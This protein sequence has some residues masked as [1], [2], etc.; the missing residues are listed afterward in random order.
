MST[1]DERDLARAKTQILDHAFERLQEEAGLSRMDAQII[2]DDLEPVL[3]AGLQ[4]VQALRSLE[5]D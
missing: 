5:A 4:A 2:I 3:V 1:L